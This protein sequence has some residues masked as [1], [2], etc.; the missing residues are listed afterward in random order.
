M[1]MRLRSG[2]MDV[3]YIDESTDS[4]IYVV[5]AV[6]VPF[7]RE[8]RGMWHIVWPDYLDAAKDWR[9]RVRDTLQIPMNKELHGVKLASGRG[10]YFKGKYQFDRPKAG[11]A[12]RQL[13]R[14][15]NFLPDES[16]LTIA[17]TKGGRPL[18]GMTRL[19]AALHALFQRMRQQCN[20][21][22][23][24]AIAFFDEGH[25]EYRKLYRRALVY[26]PTGSQ[27]IGVGWGGGEITA[28]YP[29]S[30]F[31]KDGNSKS[32]KYCHFT[33]LADLIA[34]SAFLKVKSENGT[35]TDWQQKYILDNLYD[36]FPKNSINCQASRRFPDGIVRLS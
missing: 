28:N 15:A 30:M 10:H 5:T 21:R 20:S 11:A 8:R 33:Q 35:L 25:D 23:T 19:E 2:G 31:T 29:L 32:S 14:L 1:A 36:Q 4:Q 34:Y 6:A 16:V 9:R 27:V 24:N 18:Y 17:S 7:L 26:L 12:Y 22:N 3:F 13:L